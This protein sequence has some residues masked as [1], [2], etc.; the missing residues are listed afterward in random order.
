[1]SNWSVGDR[2]LTQVVTNHLWSNLNLVENLTV[3]NTN[4][5]ANHLWDDNHVSQ[6][7]LDGSWLLVWLSRKLSSSQL[8]DQTKWFLVQTS[9]ESSSDSGVGQL[10]EV[11]GGE[12]QK[13]LEVDTSVR[14]GLESSL[15]GR[16]SCGML[17]LRVQSLSLVFRVT[18][19]GK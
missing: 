11:L 18:K 17:V 15:S 3:V 6:V 16:S 2:E 12:L 1:M 7:G 8:L 9:L 14:E 10:G 4:N 19:S 5:G 13:V